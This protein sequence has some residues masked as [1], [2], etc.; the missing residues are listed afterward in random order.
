M[1]KPREILMGIGVLGLLALAGKWVWQHSFA[2][3]NRPEVVA[4]AKVAPGKTFPV[5]IRPGPATPKVLTAAVSYS[6]E[7]S[8]VACMTCHT[9][10]APKLATH[11]AEELREFHQGLHYEHGG[12]TCLSCHNADNYDTLRK[13]DGTAVAFP[14]VRELCAQCHGPQYRDYQHGSHGGMNGYWDLSRGPRERN[15]CTNCHDPH[16]PKYP[17]VMPVFPPRDRGALQQRARSAGHQAEASDE[18]GHSHE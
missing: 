11:A 3:W 7:V 17:Q 14:N 15:T 6:G 18:G 10:K 8:A 9:T 16:A 13:A 2:S 4:A 1:F 12:Q 5:M